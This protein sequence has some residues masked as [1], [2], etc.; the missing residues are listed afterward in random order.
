MVQRTPARVQAEQ[1]GYRKSH[2]F[3]RLRQKSQAVETRLLRALGVEDVGSG[4]G[5]ESGAGGGC[6]RAEADGELSWYERGDGLGSVVVGD[7]DQA[8][9]DETFG[10]SRRNLPSWSRKSLLPELL[11]IVREQAKGGW[12]RNPSPALFPA[13]GHEGRPLDMRHRTSHEG[14]TW[15]VRDQVVG[16]GRDL[17]SEEGGEGWGALD[18]GRLL[19]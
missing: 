1:F 7:C 11:V 17:A 3:L 13:C 4:V 15:L 9:G 16:V 6:V 18:A 10:D 19:R 8:T 12:G 5:T 2:F 14:K